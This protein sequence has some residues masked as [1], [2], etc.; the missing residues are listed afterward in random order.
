[1]MPPVQQLWE[2]PRVDAAMSSTSKSKFRATN[3]INGNPTGGKPCNSGCN[4]TDP[5]LEV[6]LGGSYAVDFVL[7]HNINGK[8]ATQ[9][10]D[11]ELWLGSEQGNR[12]QRCAAVGVPERWQDAQGAHGVACVGT[13]ARFVTI[14]LPGERR[15]LSLVEL[16]VLSKEEQLGATVPVPT[17][18]S[19]V[20][21]EEREVGALEVSELTPA[22]RVADG[23]A[24]A[25][26][27]SVTALEAFVFAAVL[28]VWT[29]ILC[30]SFRCM[31]ARGK[32]GAHAI[33]VPRGSANEMSSSNADVVLPPPLKKRPSSV[34][35]DIFGSGRG[36]VAAI[37][38]SGREALPEEVH[39]RDA[40]AT[41]DG[42]PP[43]TAR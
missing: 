15:C 33:A 30:C 26:A 42:S 36:T 16:R 35:K 43:S 12:T 32:G 8:K 41:E 29:L 23:A 25:P 37:M 22:A 13:G 5:W 38:G 2:L 27:W 34:V 20:A 6:D 21:A 19:L 28:V 1:M 11:F 3:C 7:V 9:L 4:L 31:R 14:L 40:V 10:G 24:P 39:L 17:V 18:A